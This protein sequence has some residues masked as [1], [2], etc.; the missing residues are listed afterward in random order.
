MSQEEKDMEM[1]EVE[2]QEEKKEDVEEVEE[3][4]KQDEEIEQAEDA[5]ETEV[6]DSEDAVEET[7]EETEEETAVEAE[8][9]V[10][11]D[12]EEAAEEAEEAEDAEEET[13]QEEMMN[14]NDLADLEKG[15]LVEGTVVEINERGIYVDVNYKSDG[16]IPLRELSTSDVSDP[17]D[18]VEL[19][20]EIKVV[21]LTLED[22]EG[23]MVLSRKRA[24]EEEAWERIEKS[25]AEDEI[26][27]AEITKE[28]KGG[29]VA[30]VGLRG[31]IPAS[32]VA[33][34]YVEDLSQYVGD[35]LRL[36]VIEVDRGNNNVVLSHKEVLEKE[37]EKQKEQ[38]LAELEEDEKVTG[39]VTKLVDFGA[40]VDLGGIEGL[41]HISE[42]SWG[43][44]GHPSDVLEE[45]EEIEVK[46]LDVDRENERISLGL[47]QLL[48]DPWEEFADRHYEG[49]VIEGTITKIVDF[50]AFMEIE[51]GIEGLI[52]ISQLSQRHVE[53]PDEVV[54][55][56]Q[57]RDAKII[58]ID[59]DDK[60]VGLSLKELEDQQ[61]STRDSQQKEEKDASSQE[62]D[63]EEDIGDVP[64]G[65][66][67]GER[68]GD[69]KDMMGDE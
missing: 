11:E 42:M 59:P 19:D 51:D 47:K 45:G 28:V 33:I 65:A 13:S 18:V 2:E 9:D 53:T 49:E 64:S 15:Q 56:G 44:I 1:E 43:R 31:F 57:E 61:P 16:F 20:E 5:E 29:L 66:T 62:E 10:E 4:E 36:K 39:R 25:H 41:L 40:F 55:V 54:E 68:L 37:R 34:G 52:H 21:V 38:T 17:H 12:D 24:E 6:K 30:D 23:N 46:V 35:A 14:A 50:G 7:S 67:I 8:E 63:S 58:N 32:H 3:K 22:E 60:R 69:L 48:P 27:E 26:I